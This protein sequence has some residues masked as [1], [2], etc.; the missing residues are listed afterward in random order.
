MERYYIFL[1][2]IFFTI[3]V[4]SAQS[5]EVWGDI[6]QGLQLETNKNL[7]EFVQANHP[8][9]DICLMIAADGTALTIDYSVFPFI[10]LIEQNNIWLAKTDQNVVYMI[11]PITFFSAIQILKN[12]CRKILKSLTHHIIIF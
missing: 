5:I 1:L 9:T 7:A 4:L 10:E 3:S 11:K 12:Y 2:V 8:S 6:K